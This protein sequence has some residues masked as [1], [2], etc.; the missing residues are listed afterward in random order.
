MFA[1]AGHF[2]QRRLTQEN[3]LIIVRRSNLVLA[4]RLWGVQLHAPIVALAGIFGH[5]AL[6]VAA[7]GATI[8]VLNS[9]QLHHYR[10]HKSPSVLHTR[11]FST[12]YGRELLNTTY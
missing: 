9:G 1:R 6:C 2:L 7:E 3:R 5:S 11:C 4:P 8:F 12:V 10:N